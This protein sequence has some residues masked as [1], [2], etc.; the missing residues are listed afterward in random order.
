MQ[1]R[2]QGESVGPPLASEAGPSVCVGGEAGVGKLGVVLVA[3]CL[4]CAQSHVAE[5]PPSPA[6]NVAP[7]A[8]PPPPG[9]PANDG[10][11]SPQDGGTATD[12]GP[13]FG[14]PGPWPTTNEIYGA[15]DGIQ[16][17]PV[18]GVSTDETQNMWVATP[19]ALYVMR[20]GQTK[21]TRFDENTGS[22]DVP[23]QKNEALTYVGNRLH[24]ASNPVTYCDNNFGNELNLSPPPDEACPIYGAADPHGG[25]SE[26]VGGGPNEVFVGYWG[27]HTW[28]DKDGTWADPYRHTGKVDRVRLQADG[29]IE[30]V[31]FD[32]VSNDDVA[33]WHDKTVERMIY[34]HFIHPHELYVGCDHGVTKFSPDKWHAPVGWFASGPNNDE[35]MSDHLHA[36]ACYHAHCVDDSNQ[37]LGDWRALALSSSGDLWT[38]GRWAAG[39]ISY[40]ADNNKWWVTPRLQPDGTKVPA[41]KPSFGDP[42]DGNCAGNRPI[43][44]PPQEG[45]Y[46]NLSAVAVTKDPQTG[47]DKVWFSSGIVS[48]DPLDINY[49]V[50]AY[51][52]HPGPGQQAWT[53]YDP[54]NNLGMAETNVRDMVALPDGRLVLA[55]PNSGLVVWDPVTG[56]HFAIRAGGGIPSDQVYRLE[57]DTMVDPPALH[58]AT[59]GGAAVIRQIPK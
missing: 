15:A 28:D 34:D 4:A 40:V 51:L 9:P 45:D 44:C 12:A 22:P 14:G 29:S 26:I 24:L 1:H 42:Y 13:K 49:G 37:R 41:I 21:F 35:W 48:G 59:A 19:R 54:V 27:T 55:G 18:V 2:S 5:P 36:Q 39:K 53:Y 32:M 52:A 3:V 6:Q 25:I 38:G 20:P 43:F 10:G 58:V 17:S 57:V 46:V 11:A 30:V 47:Q 33:F 8:G 16:E 23:N 50:A 56:K 7:D 31:R